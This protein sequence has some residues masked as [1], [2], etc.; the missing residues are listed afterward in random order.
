[1][2]SGVL[3]A[4]G[5]NGDIILYDA[6]KII[7]GDSEVIISQSEKHTGPVRALDVNSFQVILLT[8]LFSLNFS[9]VHS[10]LVCVFV[11][12]NWF[13]INVKDQTK[14]ILDQPCGLWRKWVRN[15]HLGFEQLQLPNDSR[16]QNTG[17]D[18]LY[19]FFLLLLSFECIAH[20][21]HAQGWLCMHFCDKQTF[22]E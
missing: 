14:F 21:L 18:L 1:M 15:I 9:N 20:Y 10:K 4:G 11:T 22:I 7:A 6:S 12:K 17:K 5:E 8:N 13:M 2:P 19:S 3:I 16:T